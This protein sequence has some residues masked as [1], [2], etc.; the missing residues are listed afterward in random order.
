MKKFT[1]AKNIERFNKNTS[2]VIDDSGNRL[3]KTPITLE[4][5]K[6][7]ISEMNAG[8]LDELNSIDN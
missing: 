3:H 2:F 7:V 5:S 4:D 6:Y 1:Q 8:N